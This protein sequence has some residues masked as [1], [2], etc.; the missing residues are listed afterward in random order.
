MTQTR[1]FVQEANPVPMRSGRNRAAGM[2]ESRPA[3]C[4]WPFAQV[5][6]K[7]PPK[8]AGQWVSAPPWL[9]RSRQN[10]IEAQRPRSAPWGDG[11]FGPG[12]FFT[13]QVNIVPPLWLAVARSAG[14]EKGIVVGPDQ[15]RRLVRRQDPEHGPP[16]RGGGSC[17]R[18][19]STPPRAPQFPLS[20]PVPS[21]A[22]SDGTCGATMLA[23]SSRGTSPSGEWW[24]VA[25]ERFQ[26]GCQARQPLRCPYALATL[27]P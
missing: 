2:D 16:G 8:A 6:E 25:S 17:A 21:T 1:Y 4:S 23:A 9:P 22:A 24:G 7:V 13:D 15:A 18:R 12:R 27:G 3:R 11:P 19:S 5:G 26:S 20:A 14:V 10:R